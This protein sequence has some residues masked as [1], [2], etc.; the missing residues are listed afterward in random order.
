MQAIIRDVC[1]ILRYLGKHCLD[2]YLRTLNQFRM[3][4]FLELEVQQIEAGLVTL[5][6][7]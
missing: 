3:I 2:S 6:V 1:V 7:H 5:K 4:L